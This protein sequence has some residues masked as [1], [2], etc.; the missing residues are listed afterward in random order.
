MN[1]QLYGIGNALVDSEYLV[2]EP[3][4]D[5]SGFKKGTMTLVDAHDRSKLITLL[6]DTNGVSLSKRAGG[7]SAANTIVTAALLGTEAFYNCKVA[8]D[9]TGDFF[10]HDLIGLGIK[11]NMAGL[12]PEGVTG[13]CISMITP[14]GERTLVTHL[15]INGSLSSS[16]IDTAALAA[17]K[18]LYIEGY[19][20][21][22]ESA[23]EAVLDA[24]RIALENQVAVSLTLSDIGMVENFRDQFDLLVQRGVDLIFCNEEEAKLWTRTD[25]RLDAANA[26]ANQGSRFAMTL[27]GDG[28]YVS[29]EDETP[30][31]VSAD[32]VQALD[33]TGAGDTFAGAVLSG[34]IGGESLPTATSKG[35]DLARTVVSRFGAR[36]L[37]SDL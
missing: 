16:N 18:F 28:A 9:P 13:E 22:S 10:V 12:R 32:K 20:V 29:G 33:T 11:T 37:P 7:G 8:S 21:S 27:S 26:L 34:L 14:D 24:Q 6:E 1:C 2:S 15:G 4:L 23:F 31:F 3:M 35:H 5:Q 17:A 25:D 30:C 19:L 36:L